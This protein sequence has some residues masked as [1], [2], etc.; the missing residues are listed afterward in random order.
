MANSDRHIVRHDNGIFSKKITVSNRIGD[1]YHDN[2]FGS[3]S[4]FLDDEWIGEILDLD[5]GKYQ[6]KTRNP[7]YIRKID[8]ALTNYGDIL[9][10]IREL[11]KI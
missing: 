5:H 10:A 7:N 9:D 4:V 1:K 11:A 6:F 8:A 2:Q 3:I